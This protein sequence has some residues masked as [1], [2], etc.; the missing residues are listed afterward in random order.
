MIIPE[1]EI[2]I[3]K[4]GVEIARKTVQPGEY[5]I[6]RDPLCDVHVEDAGLS[7]R[8]ARLT[9]NYDHSFIEDLGSSNGT[10]V[11][12][13]PISEPTRMWP[14]QR[15]RLGAG[16]M[17]SLRRLK[18][19]ARGDMSIAP[20]QALVKRM[21]PEELLRDKKYDIG[22]MI[23]QGGMGAILSAREVTIDRTVAMKVMLDSLSSVDHVRFI[24]EAKVTGQL[25]HPNIVPVYEL[26]VDENG[27]VYYTMKFVQGVTLS[28]I[29][30]QLAGRDRETMRKY[31]LPV[32]LTHFQKIC[33]AVAFAH[34]RG[35]IHRDLKPENVMI[36]EYGEVLVMDWGL[37][38]VLGKME[39]SEGDLDT[40]PGCGAGDASDPAPD[41]E[42][43][44][45][46]SS[47]TMAGQILG[48]PR[49]M[50]P[51]Q[52]AGDIEHLDER[53]DIYSLG[54]ILYTIL[55]YRPPVNLD[56]VGE[57][58]ERVKK[59]A[60]DPLRS[61]SRKLKIADSLVALVKKAMALDRNDRYQSVTA[62]QADITAYQ[63]GFA[64]SAEHAS[65]A[66][67]LRLFVQR[68]KGIVATSF[69]AWF[70]IAVLAVWF[71][72]NL[73]ASEHTAILERNKAQAALRDAE[74]ISR[75]LKELFRNPD[76]TR[77][78]K[79][80]TVVEMLDAG[81]QKLG[82]DLNSLEPSHQAKLEA[83]L[84]NT[85]YSLGLPQQA[86]PLQEKVRDYYFATFG[87]A[88][89]DTIQAM[90]SLADSYMANGEMAKAAA[91]RQGLSGS[92][93]T[94]DSH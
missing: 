78:G 49:Y 42:N 29:L 67:Q 35:V 4:E 12:D 71:V 32:L 28:K 1:T 16:T 34:S 24:A 14:N 72:I 37:A 21:L 31:P 81:A 26:G 5:V 18:T 15:I 52:A 7:R 36:G 40:N 55:S 89:S 74:S 20:N 84:G 64:T 88:S 87:P 62:L 25:E 56:D 8:H 45:D 85:Y 38:K 11:N 65:F 77:D 44:S 48:T 58:L 76:P 57:V 93:P 27:H 9:I 91:I 86:I 75:F 80:I 54:A 50:S 13:N 73:R 33:D 22:G 30:K 79:T 63:A 69:V 41:Q 83:T 53:S 17:I 19:E 6:G 66:K 2:I 90:E 60:I 43:I 39:A 23:A 92:K 3:T 61:P 68:N 82:S 10:F 94:G 70:L 59:G 47:N 46:T 51:E